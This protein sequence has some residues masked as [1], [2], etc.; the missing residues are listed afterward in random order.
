MQGDE[1]CICKSNDELNAHLG[2]RPGHHQLDC[3]S[4]QS[5][6]LY[7]QN[8][9]QLSRPLHNGHL[10]PK[11]ICMYSSSA[12]QVKES[13]QNRSNPWPRC[14]FINSSTLGLGFKPSV[15]KLVYEIADLL[16][17][18]LDTL[19]DDSVSSPESLCAPLESNRFLLY[20]GT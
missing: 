5:A 19:H 13:L 3:N 8:I 17:L 11:T 4:K 7:I 1:S 2:R 20:P 18:H 14:K 16:S 10:L 6:G 12:G 15:H 9:R